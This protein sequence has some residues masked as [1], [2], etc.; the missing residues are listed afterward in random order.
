VIIAVTGTGTGVGKTHLACAL[1]GGLL[2]RGTRAIGWKPVESGVDGAAGADEALLREASGIATPTIRLR[3]PLS[4]H[5][6]ARH[7][8]IELDAAALRETLA[9]LAARWEVVVVELA[10]GL[11]SPFDDRIDIA[12]WLGAIDARVLVV[13]PDRLGVLHDVTAVVRASA[14][15]GLALH[16]IV[17]APPALPDAS[18]GT[19]LDELRARPALRE[20]M[21]TGVRRASIAE[22]R[23]DAALLALATP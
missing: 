8:G 23:C 10:G 15:V 9:E 5:L 6:A 20:L 21:I 22:L 14:S 16:A 12:E 1:V 7:E 17:L 4:P 11:F 3:A 18:T 13:A 2:D 19:N